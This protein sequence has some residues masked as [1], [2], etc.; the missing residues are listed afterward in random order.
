MNPSLAEAARTSG[1]GDA[2]EGGDVRGIGGVSLLSAAEADISS[3]YSGNGRGPLQSEL[4]DVDDAAEALADLGS[5]PQEQRRT[6]HE[7]GDAFHEYDYMYMFVFFSAYFPR[8]TALLR[9][10]ASLIFRANQR[11]RRNP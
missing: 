10:G 7:V 11:G 3:S 5:R 4:D 6:R 8:A 2:S 1:R 9:R